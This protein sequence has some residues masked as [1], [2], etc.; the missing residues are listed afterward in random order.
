[1]G[2]TEGRPMV[3]REPEGKLNL[4]NFMQMQ[5]YSALASLRI[6]TETLEREGVS[7]DEMCGHGGFFKTEYIGSCAMSAALNAPVTVMKNA[8]EGGA[9]GIALLAL[10]AANKKGTLEDFLDTIF[11]GAEKSTVSAPDSEKKKF[12]AFMERY[13]KYLAAEKTAAGK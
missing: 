1:M 11:A 7:V 12:A 4:A 8:G 2:L 9:Y 10:Y 6:G 3:L 5:I 13:K